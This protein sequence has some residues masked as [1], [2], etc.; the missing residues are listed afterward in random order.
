MP[1]KDTQSYGLGAMVDDENNNVLP[2]TSY[3]SGGTAPSFG[4]PSLSNLGVTPFQCP[5]FTENFLVTKVKRV[6][7]APNATFTL[8]MGM[9]RG[10]THSNKDWKGFRMRR[11]VSSG[12]ILIGQGE[13]STN[14]E[15][16]NKT[17][18][19][20]LSFH[21]QTHITASVNSSNRAISY[22]STN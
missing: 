4:S 7:L 19:V 6:Q 2:T 14:S 11:G 15:G 16:Q 22:I 20:Q 8:Q 10:S 18:F 17:E 1:R 13:V 12:I 3:V 21:N 9:S 5:S